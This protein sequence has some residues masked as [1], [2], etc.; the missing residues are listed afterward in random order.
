[1]Q[2]SE[3][4]RYYL[5]KEGDDFFRRNFG[6]K[7]PPRLRPAKVGIFEQIDALGIAGKAVLEYGCCYGDLLAVLAEQMPGRLCAGVEASHEALEFGRSRYGA[8]VQF[9]HG[10][11]ADNP[12]NRAEDSRGRFDLVVVDDVFGW[13]SRETLFQSI[14]S[15]DQ[16]LAEGGHLFIRDFY[17]IEKLKNRNHHVADAEVFNYK[18]P[19]SHARLFEWSGMYEIVSQRVYV[20]QTEMSAGYQSARAFGSRWADTVL[21][22]SAHGY[23]QLVERAKA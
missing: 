13:V 4:D 5:R 17:P 1:M 10:T 7:E 18:I 16:V 23:Y 19:G 20:D 11:I 8:R 9:H 15:I 2:T 14:A 21:R 6:G 12:L 22:K 3:Q